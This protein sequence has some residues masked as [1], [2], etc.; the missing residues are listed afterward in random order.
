MALRAS[1]S[2]VVG[3]LLATW[4]AVHA[5]WLP[6]AGHG[7]AAHFV[8]PTMTLALGLAAGL[9]LVTLQALQQ[10]LAGRL[11]PLQQVLAVAGWSSRAVR[12]RVVWPP[13]R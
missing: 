5:N 13:L 10:V 12:V 9:S 11:G 6:A 4:L 8:L 2:F 3:L 1:P 7:S